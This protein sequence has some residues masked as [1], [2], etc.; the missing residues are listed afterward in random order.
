[1]KT[2]ICL[3]LDRSG[4][5][6]GRE[7]D[8]VGGVNTFLDEQKKLPDPASVA[9]RHPAAVH[10]AAGEPKAVDAAKPDSSTQQFR[11]DSTNLWLMER[12]KQR[13]LNVGD[14]MAR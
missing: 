6:N 13:L 11:V 4:S 3:I 10:A 12:R 5:M 8:V 1:M 9:T 7:K 14:E 2:M